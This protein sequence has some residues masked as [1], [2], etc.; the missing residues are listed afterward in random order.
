MNGSDYNIQLSIL[1]DHYII[2]EKHI[3]SCIN[4]ITKSYCDG[5]LSI[6]CKEEICRESIDSVFLHLLIE[7][8]KLKYDVIN[9]W[10]S[11]KGCRIDYGRPLI[12]YEFFCN[13]IKNNKIFHLSG[14]E[15][16]AKEFIAVG[17]RCYKK[18][19]LICI[20][21][22]EKLS[23]V[24]INKINENIIRLLKTKAN[25]A[26]TPDRKTLAGLSLK[27]VQAR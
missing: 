21:D 3:K 11:S 23:K 18:Q 7:K 26:S 22:F 19:H 27:A 8:Q 2:L 25:K 6:C 5:C 9:G 4:K 14:V 10:M 13:K 20:I 24:K 17:D 1:I 12:C 16:L 15:N